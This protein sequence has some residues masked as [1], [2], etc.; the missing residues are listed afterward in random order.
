MERFRAGQTYGVGFGAG[1]KWIGA[2]RAV[3]IEIYEASNA[4]FSQARQRGAKR[5]LHSGHR[6]SE[7]H[8]AM[9]FRENR[10]CRSRTA[11][12]VTQSLEVFGKGLR[13]SESEKEFRL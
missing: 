8:R 12:S 2:L 4:Q 10:F 7:A 3:G 5:F 13:V 9:A 6:H 1:L 11:G